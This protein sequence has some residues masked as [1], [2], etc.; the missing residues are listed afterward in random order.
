MAT[1]E[2]RAALPWFRRAWHTWPRPLQGL[3][4]ITMLGLFGAIC[5]AALGVTHTAVFTQGV[6]KVTGW[7]SSLGA[8]FTALNA[9]AGAIVAVLKQLNT[10]VVMAIL[11]AA[12]L[13]YAIFLALGTMYFRLA[14]AKR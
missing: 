5:F 4:L 13:G 2:M 11:I 7:F 9:L 3:F 14:F 6:Q 10:A 1:I 8:I 12:G